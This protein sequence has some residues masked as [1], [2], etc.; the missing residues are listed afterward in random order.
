MQQND[1]RGAEGSAATANAGSFS[2]TV[3]NTA[4]QV[5][6]AAAGKLD[7][8]RAATADG[9]ESTAAALESQADE[10]PGGEFV[11]N[12]AH[13]AAQSMRAAATRVRQNDVRSMLGNM[14]QVV[15]NYPGASVLTAAALGFLLTR[16]LSRD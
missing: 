15:R 16:A 5:G 6:Q 9:L 2:G 10:L 8:G 14:R 3:R 12:A 1:E 13:K 11:H 4:T 7:E